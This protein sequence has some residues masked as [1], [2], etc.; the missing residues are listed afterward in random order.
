M[1]TIKKSRYAALSCVALAWSSFATSATVLISSD[2][3]AATHPVVHTVEYFGQLVTQRSKGELSVVVKSDGSAGTEMDSMRA[4]QEG[5]QA[6]TRVSLGLLGDKLPAAELASLPYLF[7]SSAHM[8]KV[9]NGDFGKRLDREM[10]EAGYVR[11]MYL[12]SAPRDFYCMKPIHSQADFV[13]KKVRVMPSKVF[14][15]LIQNLGAKPV[16]MSFS[17]VGEALKTGALDCSDGGTVN[18]VQAG[19][20][21]IAP[22]LIQDEHLLMPEVL[23]MSKKVWDTL[24]P[25]QQEILRTAGRDGTAYMSKLWQDQENTALATAKK[26]GVTVITRSQIS[27]TAIEAL[28]IKTYSKYVKNSSDLETVMKIMTIK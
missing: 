25:A 15:D 1:Q 9:L 2:Q 17:Q 4:V 11:L 22:Y 10:L 27:M 20:H 23:L 6:M 8:W 28:A 21:K 13:G 7:R 18:F 5:R 26:A 19:H 16:S 24:P 14:E 3:Q 12:D